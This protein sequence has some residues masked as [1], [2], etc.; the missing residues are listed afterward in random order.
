M[1][2]IL[3]EFKLEFSTLFLIL[4]VFLMTVV[5]TGNIF[6]EESPDLLRR[7]HQDVGG[8]MIWLDVIAPIML[9]VAVY[10]FVT[11]LKMSREFGKLI[12]TKSKA[13]FIR[14]QDRIEELAFGLTEDHR[15]RLQ[16]KKREFKIKT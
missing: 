1:A 3:Q 13:T 10:Y 2:K 8:W 16:E 14:N 4:G 11:T 15:R 6:P 5:I 12:E 7:V 9:L